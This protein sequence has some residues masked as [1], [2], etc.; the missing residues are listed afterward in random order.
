MTWSEIKKAVEQAGVRDDEEIGSFREQGFWKRAI[1]VAS[2]SLLCVFFSVAHAQQTIFNVPSTDVLDRGK[3][4]AELDVSFKPTDSA[5]VNRFSSFVPRVVIGTGS[6]IEIGLNITGNIQPGADTTTLAPA[7]KWKPYQGKDNGVAIAVGDHLFF[8]I[9]NRAY[10]AG[11]YVYTEIS[12]TFKSGTRLTAGGYDFT[13][14]V[15]AT[16]NRAGGQFGFEQPVNKKVSVAADWF[17]GK[18]AAGY[19]TPGLVFKVGP[20]ITGYAGYSIGNQNPSKGNHFFLLE[21]GYNFN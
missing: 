19:F 16:A 4:Y 1:F 18:H 14:N 15:V 9:R 11:N 12:K 7:I 6:R 17:T 20:K 10:D 3:V 13:R 2:C 21:L 5:A 8:P